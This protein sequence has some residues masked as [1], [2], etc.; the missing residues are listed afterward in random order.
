MSN[1]FLKPLLF[2]AVVFV[3]VSVYAQHTAD[4]NRV[5]QLQTNS[6][7]YLMK[8][9][10]LKRDLDSALLLNEEA[11]KLSAALQYRE[12]SGKGLLLEAQIYREKGEWKKA[13]QLLKEALAMYTTYDL[14]HLLAEGYIESAQYY[15]NEGNDLEQRIYYYNKA[16]PL[17]K[18]TGDLKQVAITL[19]VLGDFCHI[20]GDIATSLNYL[21]ESLVYSKVAGYKDVQGIYDLIGNAYQ[22]KG[23]FTQALKY[24]LLAVKTAETL[25]DSSIQMGAIY[26]HVGLIYY[27]LREYQPA[28]DY[29][30]KALE[31]AITHKDTASYQ[32]ITSNIASGLLMVEQY[33]DA[34]ALLDAM[35]KKYPPSSLEIRL[36]I[37]YIYFNIYMDMKNYNKAAVYYKEIVKF[38]N[39]LSDHDA[40]QPTLC[41][42]IIRYLIQTKQYDQTYKYLEELDNTSKVLGDNLVRSLNQLDWF[43]VD[44]AQGNYISAIQHQQLYKSLSDS[45]FNIEKS[46]QFS[47]LQLQFE[48]EKK[49]KDIQL[50]TQ[51]SKLQYNSLQKERTIRNVI[52]AGVILLSLFSGLIYISYRSKERSNTKLELQQKEINDQNE[53][54]KK[55]LGEKE[56]LLKEIHHRVKNNLQIVISL[57]NTQSAYLDNEDALTA[58]RN[59]QYRMHAMSLIHQKLYQ[60][61]NLDCIEMSWYIRELV[62]YMQESF[63]TTNRIVFMLQVEKVE[64]DVAKAVPLGLI[65]N[66]AISNAIKY[67]FPGNRAG[68][69]IISLKRLHGTTYQLNISDNG[70]GLP[71]DFEPENTDSLGM[72]LMHG[73]SEQLEGTFNIKNDNGLKIEIVFNNHQLVYERKNTDRR[74]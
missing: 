24:G 58:I 52:I 20:K 25:K 70:V 60:S 34:L 15:H 54:L 48:T 10:E 43:R 32:L 63:N 69:V 73:L 71:E 56:W 17:F 26:N 44:S 50:L 72:S 16:L 39:E 2:A 68:E 30:N 64:M 21:Q 29:W 3:H 33:K 35:I 28:R 51:K 27:N 8:E 74:R 40:A 19:Q 53:L 61:D 59:S 42:S 13:A 11:L 14:K 12:G 67:A 45:I 37:P 23:D 4:T 18:E 6:R 38:H 22:Q 41:R 46:K 1:I 49:D 31:V 5:K 65:L 66:E 47:S 57:L 36:R 7:Y 62:S 55:L 9:G